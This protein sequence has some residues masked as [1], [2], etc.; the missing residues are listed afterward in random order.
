MDAYYYDASPS[1]SA[2]RITVPTLAASAADD[3]LCNV[4]GLRSIPRL[5]EGLALVRTSLGGHLAWLEGAGA[6][7]SSYMD[8]IALQW[9]D[10]CLRTSK[11]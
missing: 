3:P 5:G 11:R 8:R 1:K 2:H 4:A 10:A 9:I 6:L 7:G